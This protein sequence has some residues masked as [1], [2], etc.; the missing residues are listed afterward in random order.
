MGEAGGFDLNGI[1]QEDADRKRDRQKLHREIT[2]RE[3][4]KDYVA[5]DAC[6]V[7]NSP[8]RILEINQDAGI[9]EVPE[10][11][12]WFGADKR[13]ELYRELYGIDHVI[14]QV[15]SHFKVGASKGST[16]K[17][18][19]VLVGPPG[20]GK[21][22][23]VKINMQAL[24]DYRKKPIFMIKNC[25]KFEEPLHLIPRYMRPEV[26]LRSEDCPEYPDCRHKHLHLGV[27]IEGDLC[28]VCRHLL[29][30]NFKDSDGVIRWWDVPVETFTFSIQGRRGIGSFEPSG[31]KVADV[32]A[33][34]GR[35]N[36]G[37]TSTSGYNHPLAFELCGEIPAGER[38]ITEGREILACDPEVLRVFFSV[39]EEKELKVQG[40][41]FPHLSVDT[42][43]IG[44]T[45]LTV[46]KEFSHNKKYEGLHDRFFIVPVPYPLRIKDEV[47]LYRKLI[48]RESNFVKLKRCHIAPGT[49]E[50]AAAFA[51]MTRLTAS[52]TGIDLLTKAKV[53]NGDKILSELEDKEK[54]PIDRTHLLE[55]GQSLADISKREGMF[56]V[57]SR[58]ILAALNTA[59]SQEA[60]TNGCLTPLAAI[61]ALREVFD[62]RMGFSSEEIDRFKM[63]LSAGD[64]K[65]V[66][67]EYEEFVVKTITKAYLRG[68]RDLAEALFWRY[69]KEVGLYL[70]QKARLIKGQVLTIER[71]PIT[72]KPREADK[73]FMRSI[74]EE[75]PW[76]EQE[77]EVARG[78][79]FIYKAIHPNF[80]YNYYSPLALACEKRLMKDSGPNLNIVISDDMP[81]N[82]EAKARRRD[83]FEALIEMGFCERKCIKEVIERAREFIHK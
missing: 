82:E 25:P 57:S 47:Q 37:I 63:F 54:K 75:I 33:L 44:H 12:R 66:M 29:E 64:M 6:I 53:Y 56:G 26:A 45:N 32:N 3:Y 50:L 2:F 39:A 17:Q 42:M 55:E 22:T 67:S 23:I 10:N 14:I 21:S 13:Y 16:G 78:E 31:E 36:I 71:D 7:Q 30:D 58:T 49:L 20:S 46:F 11:E 5:A 41:S 27:K 62:H 74:E 35:E 83:L 15:I 72:N 40:S 61:K 68:F 9:T 76:T 34:T 1:I 8:S 80:D 52:S 4:I 38:G 24:E 70:G 69:L 81:K 51:V 19:L 59:L 43:V 77:A 28:Q 65:N 48:E 60:D 79:L 73:K 18:V